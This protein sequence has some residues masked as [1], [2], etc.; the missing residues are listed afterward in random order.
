MY[1]SLLASTT[2]VVWKALESYGLDSATLFKRAGLDPAQVENPQAR[3]PYSA[4]RKL[5]ELAI[6]ESGDPCFALIAAQQWHPSNFHALGYAWLASHSLKEAMERLIRYFRVVTTDPEDLSLLEHDKEYEFVIDTS[7]VVYRGLDAE[8][9]L[10]LA[11]VLDAC[12]LA[13]GDD[14]R[15]KRVCLQ[16]P[17][18]SCAER[19]EA[20]FGCPVEFDAPGYRMFFDKSSLDQSLPTGNAEIARAN[21]QVILTYLSQL[22]RSDTVMRVKVAL[23][24]RLP[25]SMV[26]KEDVADVLNMSSRTLLRKLHDEDTSFKQLLDETRRE[27]A[28]EYIKNPEVSIGEITYLL[29]FS[30]P[31]NFTRAF[32]RWTG[33]A[34]ISFRR[35][36]GARL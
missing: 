2:L 15:S 30:E 33:R 4:V 12:R 8:Y 18:P 10:L 6:Q 5:W 32:K 20:F 29:G 24:E 19:Y 34:P 13:K 22:N 16:R 21:D 7:S 3:Y 14:F 1:S 11:L 25:S 31:S 36:H 23:I 27:L 17:P 26:S 9:D 28:E 35:S